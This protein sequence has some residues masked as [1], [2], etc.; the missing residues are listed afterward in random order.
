MENNKSKVFVAG[1]NLIYHCELPSHLAKTG[2]P[3][4]VAR[5]EL[6]RLDE[7]NGNTLIFKSGKL[8][9]STYIAKALQNLKTGG[10]ICF[11]EYKGTRVMLD[12]SQYFMGGRR[13]SQESLNSTVEA[14]WDEQK[15]D[16]VKTDGCGTTL[17]EFLKKKAEVLKQ[18]KTTHYETK[19][20]KSPSSI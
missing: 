8:Y 14:E 13:I 1:E 20:I 7:R 2:L 3:K 9:A 17:K 18:L 10:E 4:N 15:G 5:T 16:F 11:V 6:F 19:N 12:A